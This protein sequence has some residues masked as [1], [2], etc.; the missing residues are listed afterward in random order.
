MLKSG[1]EP[2]LL[3]L[4]RARASQIN[5]CAYYI[6]MHTREARA[7]NESEERPYLL[8]AWRESP[9][10]SARERRACLRGG[11]DARVADPRA[12]EERRISARVASE[13]L[14]ATLENV[15]SPRLAVR[16]AIARTCKTTT[17]SPHQLK[18]GEPRSSVARRERI[19]FRVIGACCR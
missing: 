1:L 18:V 9:L 5:G 10:Y 19:P 6:H 7:R 15:T 11:R 4:V 12:C 13:S 3:N 14:H 16:T 17:R 8:D 2:R